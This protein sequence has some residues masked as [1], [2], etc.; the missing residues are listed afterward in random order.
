MLRRAEPEQTAARCANW[1][2]GTNISTCPAGGGHC[3][4]H[5]LRS[6]HFAPTPIAT[7]PND[8]L[9]FVLADR[10]SAAADRPG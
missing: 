2:T 3:A 9:L 7:P 1:R 10:A 4:Y 6:R 8:F 5:S